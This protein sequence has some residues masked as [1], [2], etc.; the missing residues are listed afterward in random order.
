VAQGRYKAGVG[1]VGEV[2]DAQSAL[3]EARRQKV[4]AQVERLTSLTQLSVATGRLTPPPA[5]PR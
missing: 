5:A 3:A 1:S 4:A 2:L